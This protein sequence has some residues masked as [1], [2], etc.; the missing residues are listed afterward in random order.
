MNTTFGFELLRE[1]NLP[2]INSIGRLYRHAKTGAELLS[3]VNDDEN[4]VFG[5][6]FRTPPTDSS[7]IAHILEHSVLCGSRKYPVKDPFVQLLKG[8]LNTFLNAMTF[9]D[10]TVYPVASQNLQDFYNLVDVYLDAVFYPRIGP[11]VM[12]QEGWHYELEALD[13][14]LTYKGVVYNEMKGNYS[15]PDG[16]L[17]TW[18][19]RA[20]FPDTTYGLDSG[21]DP[22]HIPDLT[23]EQ[24]R[25]FHERYY[26]PSNARILFYGDDDP[27]E[28]LRVLDAYLSAFERIEIASDIALQPRFEAPRHLTKTFAASEPEDHNAMVTINWMLD[29]IVDVE[30]ALA[31]KILDY[32]LIGTPAAPLHKAL[33]DSGLGGGL[34]GGGLTSELRQA[35]YSTGLKDIEPTDAGKVEALVLATLT[36]LAEKGIDPLTI[37]AALNTVEFSLRE[38]NTGS[39]PRGISIML[40]ALDNWLYERDPMA[41]IAFDAPL[42]AIK[43]QVAAGTRYFEGLIARYFVGNPHRATVLLRPDPDQAQREA[44]EEEA[45]LARA[46]AAMSPVDLAAVMDNGRALKS[47]QETPDTPEALAS[48][49]SLKLSD[50]PRHNKPIPVETSTVQGTKVLHHDLFT[51]GIVYLDLGFDLHVLPAELLPYV[52][53]FGRALLET[54]AGD[55]DFVALSQRIGRATG[56]I[57]PTKFVSTVTPTRRATAWLFLRGKAMPE[58]AGELLAILGDVLRRPRLDNRERFRQIVLQEKANIESMLVPAGSYFA[59]TRLRASLSEAGW[60]DEQMAGV[61]YLS[62][63]RTLASDIESNW[64]AVQTALE[65][66]REALVN[67]TLMLC[68]VTTDASTWHGFT[69][70]LAD[71]LASLPLAAA[72]PADWPAAQLPAA[73][74][75]TIPAAVNY[76]AKGADLYSLG[77]ASSGAT[78]VVGRYMSASYLW[79]KVRVQGG[80]YGGSCQFDRRS[81]TFTFSSYRDPNL[82]DTLDIYDAA[83]GFL[84]QSALSEAE[85]TRGIIGAIGDIDTYQLPDAKGFTSMTRQLVGD[86]DASLQRIREEVLATDVQDFRALG[87][88]LEKVAKSGRVVVLGS[89]AAINAANEQRA[90]FLAVSKVM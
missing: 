89:E 75:L 80:A 78:A 45:R 49:P 8:S 88:V 11:H 22:Q 5:I 51:G 90:D 56:G 84:K 21:G 83:A 4:K 36:E 77:Y 76:V 7:G 52:R 64:P 57:E 10:K 38:N 79:D 13:A 81:G 50:L 25:S 87:D 60:L 35:M 47:R 55:Q 34:A 71:F 66:I 32:I 67:R 26:H 74:G 58:K 65:S 82:L 29:E 48:I 86:S 14:P 19:Q 53:V 16:M 24:F 40:R 9:P 73:E 44:A 62:F 59:A 28:R 3:L 39:F 30:A 2:E 1:Q 42:A 41:P 12:E 31:L 61:G 63:L 72:K 43:A 68:N 18:S 54:G 70:Q 27:Q 69:P 33:L 17:A 85:L 20:L 23:F 46:R 37:E 15:S 6:T